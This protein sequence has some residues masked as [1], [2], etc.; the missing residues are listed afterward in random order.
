MTKG[1]SSTYSVTVSNILSFHTQ[2]ESNY[3]HHNIN[4]QNVDI[5]IIITLTMTQSSRA[6]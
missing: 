2:F 6:V 5:L 1:K 3:S 4:N